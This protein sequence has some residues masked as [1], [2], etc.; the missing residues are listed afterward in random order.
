MDKQ[1]SLETSYKELSTQLDQR[2]QESKKL[3]REL[4]KESK[5]V[6]ERE[7]EVVQ[8]QTQLTQQENKHRQLVEKV[9]STAVARV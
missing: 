6:C 2:R 5:M 8:L 9:S 1:F 4:E 7:K 3:V